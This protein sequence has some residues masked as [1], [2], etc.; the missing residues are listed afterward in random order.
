MKPQPTAPR[1]SRTTTAGLLLGSALA[2]SAAAVGVS[3][4]LPAPAGQV[5]RLQEELQSALRVPGWSNDDWGV[6]VVSLDHGDTLF[7]HRPGAPLLPASNMKLFTS[8]AALHYLGPDFRYGTYLAATAPIENGVLQG[9]LYVYGT[10]DPTLS[11][12]YLDT[13][14][15]IWE[16]FADTLR[17]LGVRAIRGAVV[18]DASY[19]DGVG[20]G[21]GWQE[22]YINAWY[23]APSSALTY[24]D[25]LVTLKVDP[26][27]QAGWR[28][29]VTR[30]PG[31]QGIGMVNLATT[32]ESGRR[33]LEVTRVAYDGPIVIRGELPRGSGT[34][35]RA[36]PVADPARYAAAVFRE[37]LEQRGIEVAGGVRSVHRPEGS[38]FTGRRVFAPA[39]DDGERVRV[40][41]LHRSPTLLEILTV[42]NKRSHNLYAEQVLR[43]VGRV[44]TG[45]GSTK[46]GERAILA[47]LERETDGAPVELA[48]DDGSGLSVLNRTSAG[49]IVALLDFMADSPLYEAY[50]ATL[51]E[52]GERGLRRMG[53]SPAV[54]NLRAKT[55]TINNVSALSGYVTAAN[56]ERLAFSI[57]ANDVPST[58]RAKRIEDRIGARL[59]AFSR[60]R[61]APGT[62]P[63]PDTAGRAPAAEAADTGTA[64]R[65][66][67]PADT[68]AGP[69]QAGPEESAPERHVI[70]SGD[71][72]DGIA[73]QYGTTVKA[74]QEANPGLN[75]RR[76]IPGREVRLP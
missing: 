27:E 4:A 21:S 63:A 5:Q 47:M 9:D 17:A 54:G 25:N 74:L 14:S 34:L 37:V 46:A 64:G 30:V 8:A 22:S 69:V 59:A 43:T 28:P 35:W 3:S 42:V 55:G 66:A 33:T 75:P 26:A 72:L 13:D 11:G 58:W 10:G 36:V 56:G 41:A 51:P 52:A 45:T 44:A 71:T 49:T 48:M 20:T 53:D 29:T 68:A 18:G 70:R 24:N 40:L 60:P 6:L 12:K 76:L 57:M 31:G 32:V 2:A 15:P 67:E 23:A 19:F 65:R 38:P 7:Q 61:P 1:R 62:R 73:K 16:A 50:H 39:F